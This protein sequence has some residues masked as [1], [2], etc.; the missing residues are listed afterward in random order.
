[1]TV[2]LGGE[3]RDAGVMHDL[4]ASERSVG[5]AQSLERHLDLAPSARTVRIRRADGM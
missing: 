5:E 4:F 2:E 1:M 3:C